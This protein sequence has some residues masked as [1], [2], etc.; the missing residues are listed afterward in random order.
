MANPVW[1]EWVAACTLALLGG[2]AVG[3]VHTDG[4]DPA[5]TVVPPPTRA[6]DS[7]PGQLPP[8]QEGRDQVRRGPVARAGAGPPAPVPP[9]TVQ[10]AQQPDQSDA[11]DD[12]SG[13]HDRDGHGRSGKHDRDDPRGR[14]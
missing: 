12:R 5:Q 3:A 14:G 9:V 8:P 11:P 7:A 6:Y 2:V 4:K 1:K 10:R 13:K